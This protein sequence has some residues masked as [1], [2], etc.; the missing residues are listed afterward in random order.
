MYDFSPLSS[1]FLLYELSFNLNAN[2]AVQKLH[3]SCMRSNSLSILYVHCLGKNCYSLLYSV[4]NT[5]SGHQVTKNFSLI[6]S[7][8]SIFLTS[9]QKSYEAI[10]K[11]IHLK[12]FEWF[13]YFLINITLKRI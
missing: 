9:I 4:L 12:K 5:A 8:R 6:F 10:L 1:P 13:R 11:S 2:S 7:T 3:Y